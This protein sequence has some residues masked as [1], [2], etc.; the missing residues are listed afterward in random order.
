MSGKDSKVPEFLK[1]KGYKYRAKMLAAGVCLLIII[2]IILSLIFRGIASAIKKS[3]SKN[4]EATGGGDIVSSQT[5]SQ[6]PSQAPSQTESAASS[7]AA[8]TAKEEKFDADG[9][10]IIDT[11]TLDGK[12]AIAIT[13]DDGPGEYTQELIEGLNERKARATFFMVGKCVEQH[14]EVLPMMVA[15]GHQ[16][17]NHTYNHT[18]IASASATVMNNEIE[19]TDQAIF[20]AC[21]QRSTAFRPPYGSYT[22]DLVKN[23]DKTVTL[24]SLDTTDWK[25]RDVKSIKSIIVSQSKDGSIILLHD[26][27]KTSV[28]GALAAIDELQGEGFIFVTV[29][30]LMTRYGYTISN[31][32]HSAQYAVYETNSPHA[33]EYKAD[34]EN[35]KKKADASSAAGAF[36]YDRETDTDYDDENDSSERPSDSTST[37]DDDIRVIETPSTSSRRV[38]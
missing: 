24:W 8:P 26:L 14:P 6:I 36:Y 34:A 27:Y 37:N 5:V 35:D 3:D 19:Q 38:Y 10:L 17:G 4:A 25:T 11:D 7:Q 23:I 33:D 9:K 30:E 18:D 2:I 21:G 28:D 29:D 13:F 16:L 31:K 12:K 20:N 15:G 32:A 1:I 22:N